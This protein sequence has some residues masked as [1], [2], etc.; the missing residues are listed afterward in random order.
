MNENRLQFPEAE[1]HYWRNLLTF[2]LAWLIGLLIAGL[3]VLV[4]ERIITG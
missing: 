1:D 4:I 2:A 3:G